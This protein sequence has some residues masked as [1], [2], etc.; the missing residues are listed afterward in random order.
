MQRDM[1]SARIVIAVSIV[2]QL[3]L[4]ISRSAIR[5]GKPVKQLKTKEL[6]RQKRRRME[7]YSASWNQ[8]PPLCCRQSI[9]QHPSTATSSLHNQQLIW[10]LL[11]PRSPCSAKQKLVPQCP[12][13]VQDLFPTPLSRH[14]KIWSNIYQKVS[15]KLQNLISWQCLEEAQRNSMTP[16]HEMVTWTLTIRLWLTLVRSN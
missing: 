9:I 16:C 7:W 6:M 13:L 11:L 15:L 14:Y 5:A 4:L 10:A 3:G 8:K 2:V 1:P 12:G